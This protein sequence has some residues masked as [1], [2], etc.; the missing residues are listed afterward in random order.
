MADGVSSGQAWYQA[1]SL[2][3]SVPVIDVLSVLTGY[4]RCISGLWVAGIGCSDSGVVRMRFGS[5]SWVSVAVFH[6]YGPVLG[7]LYSLQVII[8]RS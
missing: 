8:Y 7:G 3:Y 2:G 1:V 6:R 4:E 5:G